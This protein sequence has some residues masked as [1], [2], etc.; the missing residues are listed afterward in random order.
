MD[1]VRQFI[2]GPSSEDANVHLKNEIRT[3]SKLRKIEHTKTEK[4]VI[5]EKD[6]LVM[7]EELGLS[8]RENGK[9]RGIMKLL[10]VKMS[11]EA[12]MRALAKKVIIDYVV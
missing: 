1:N 7:N 9:M 4:L 2:A 6:A 8:W 11:G 10:G 3:L 12:K 5:K